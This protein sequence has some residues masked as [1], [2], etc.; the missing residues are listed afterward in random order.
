MIEKI[1][2]RR[3]DTLH[4]I[5]RCFSFVQSLFKDRNAPIW[6]IG[7]LVVNLSVPDDEDDEALWQSVISYRARSYYGDI[8]ILTPGDVLIMTSR[9]LTRLSCF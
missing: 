7:N 3:L 8:I 5:L 2:A 9:V 6:R 1:D 4:D